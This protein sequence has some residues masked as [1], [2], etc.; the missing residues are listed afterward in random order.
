MF[1][2]PKHRD[3]FWAIYAK[4]RNAALAEATRI[5]KKEG[6]VM[7][8]ER[9]KPVTLNLTDYKIPVNTAQT[10]TLKDNTAIFFGGVFNNDTDFD[11]VQWWFGAGVRWIGEW[12]V[13]EV[14][15]TEEKEG[16]WGGDL[17]RYA[18]KGRETFRYYAHSTTPADTIVDGWWIGFA[19]LPESMAETK[20]VE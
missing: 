11:Y 19:V 3:Q 1:F 12:F 18:F 4:L 20:I 9:I 8:V 10:Y 14:A 7:R 2:Y 15:F 5:G 17:S 6:I 16:L 13:R